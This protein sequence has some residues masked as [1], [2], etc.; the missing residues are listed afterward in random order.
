MM[1]CFSVFWGVAWKFSFIPAGDNQNAV[2]EYSNKNQG[3]VG[4]RANLLGMFSVQGT[5]CPFHLPTFPRAHQLGTSSSFSFFMSTRGSCY[6]SGRLS[7]GRGGAGFLP[8]STI[9]SRFL[10]LSTVTSYF[11]PLSSLASYFSLLPGWTPATMG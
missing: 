1:I 8:L 4:C 2:G 7:G 10:P 6:P 9:T 5:G 11:L 3:S